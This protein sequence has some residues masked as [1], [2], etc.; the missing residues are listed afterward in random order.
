MLTYPEI[1]GDRRKCL[2][3]TSLTPLEFEHLLAAFARAYERLHPAGRTAA[4]RPRLRR[5]GGGRKGALHGPERK[6]LSLLVH[7]KTYPVQVLMAELFGLSQPGVNYWLGRLLPGLRDALD[8]L[9]ALPEREGQAVARAKPSPRLIIDGTERRRQ[10]PKNPENQAAHYSG[11]KK[12][13]CDKN[14]V[15]AEVGSKRIDYLSGSYAGRGADKSIADREGLTYP[16]GTVLYK[17]SGFQ[18]YEPAGTKTRQ[19]KKKAGRGRVNGG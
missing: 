14:V 13:P 18:G 4:G 17:D 5:A 9:G 7:L 8:E 11:R 12:T 1:R 19:A 3:L 16:R 10:R 6:L 15:V 2:S